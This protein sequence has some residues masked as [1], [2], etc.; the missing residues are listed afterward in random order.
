MLQINFRQAVLSFFAAVIFSGCGSTAKN[1][2]A[3]K[4]L[5]RIEPSPP[6]VVLHADTPEER[7]VLDD[8]FLGIT[9]NGEAVQGLFPIK[10]TGLSTLPVQQAVEAFLS[11][12]SE[13]QKEKC[14]FP[15][16][17]EEWRRWHNIELYEREGI[18]LFE[19]DEQQLKLAFNILELSL[20]AD[21]LVKS[22]NIMAMEAYLK[23]I[24]TE[25]GNLNKEGLAR[26]G[27]D[28]YWFTFMGTPSPTEP[29]GWQIDGHHLII[30]FFVLADQVVM[31]PTFMGSELTYIKD[32][33]NAGVRTFESEGKKALK[34]YRS[35][36]NEQKVLATLLEE[37][38][39]SYSQA[40]AFRDNEIIPYAGVPVKGFNKQQMKLLV[41][42]IEEYVGNMA[43]NH[44]RVKM[45]EVLSQLDY[46]WFSWVGGSGDE[47]VFYYR[48]QSPVIM[49]EYDHHAPVFVVQKGEPKKGPVNWHVHTVVRTPNGNDYG[50][51]LLKQHLEKHH[52]NGHSHG[53]HSHED[54][55]THD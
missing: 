53:G 43:E 40:E 2:N 6:L 38:N 9:T 51:D 39:R 18:A 21:G 44:A 3:D 22:K 14:S 48:I 1:E 12:L 28:K 33:P 17:D 11:S 26:L 35:L 36:D 23:E 42:L 32:G 15:V 25:L 4:S 30:N 47:D 31:T 24:S 20:S 46:T 27:D 10:S 49:I 45:E 52:R 7:A 5:P 54:G 41:D 8:P 37:K 50:K 16:E 55:H 34:L 19:L 13:S 29:W